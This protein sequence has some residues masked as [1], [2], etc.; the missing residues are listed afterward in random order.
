MPL[1][2]HENGPSLRLFCGAPGRGRFLRVF[3]PPRFAL[4]PLTDVRA[5]TVSA[6]GSVSRPLPRFDARRD[7]SRLGL[8]LACGCRS[9]GLLGMPGGLAR[10]LYQTITPPEKMAPGPSWGLILWD[11]GPISP[12]RRKFGQRGARDQ[13]MDSGG[14]RPAVFREHRELRVVEGTRPFFGIETPQNSIPN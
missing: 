7:A 2:R 14:C 4:V 9:E 11:P 10:N 12:P 5:D 13:C 6:G 1:S 8:D 3:A